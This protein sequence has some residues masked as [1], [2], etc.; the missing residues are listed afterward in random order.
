V[1]GPACYG[2][3][4]TEATVTDAAVVQGIFD[5]TEFL[6]GDIPLY[7]ELAREA[8][9]CHVG[10]PLGLPVEEAAA[11]I[12]A[13]A[14]ANMNQAIR[15]LSVERGHDIRG[16]SLLAFG[17]AG[18]FCAAYMARDLGM[19]EIIAPRH[20]GVFAAAGLL[21]TDLR[22]TA[23]TAWQ[24]PLAKVAA[25]DI[26]AGL[27][28]LR[29]DLDRELERD[30]VTPADR[31]FR[32]AADMRCVGQFHRLTV[33]LPLPDGAGWWQPGQLA[34]TFHAA[35]DKVYGHADA[36]VPIEFVNLRAEGFGRVPQPP[37]QPD[38][39]PAEGSPTPVARRRVYIDRHVGWVD[40]AIHRRDDLRRGHGC[41]GPA[42]VIQRDS[43]V[44]VLPDQHAIVDSVGVIR[45]RMSHQ[46]S[47]DSQR[48]LI[49]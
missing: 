9:E 21:M 3:G 11:G 36:S 2:H 41:R 13:I 19:A 12:V 40:C 35:H 32:F 22:H 1:P 6:G 4:G 29:A 27:V 23:Q 14:C 24:R 16:F 26:H 39:A 7:P 43:T 48:A 25:T 34:A 5:P 47:V 38:G 15:T 17:G 31:Y 42:I 10:E 49:T 20:P 45:I 28:A 46:S 37:R 33:P 44:L 8:V 30:G 18:P